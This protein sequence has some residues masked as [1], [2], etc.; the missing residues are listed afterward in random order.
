MLGPNYCL[1]FFFQKLLWSKYTCYDVEI[2]KE[3]K[4]SLTQHKYWSSHHLGNV[5][6][7]SRQLFLRSEKRWYI[8]EARRDVEFVNQLQTTVFWLAIETTNQTSTALENL[9]FNWNGSRDM[10]QSKYKYKCRR[11][12]LTSVHCKRL[13]LP[14]AKH[15]FS[16][17]SVANK[18]KETW[19]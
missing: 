10:T 9:Y 19:C 16:S 2:K 8:Y 1:F 11:H 4:C 17:K 18:C 6:K 14:P 12:L 5:R 7:F 15:V 3:S 13:L